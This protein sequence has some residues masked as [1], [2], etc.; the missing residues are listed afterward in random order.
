MKLPKFN[1]IPWYI[2][3]AVPV[4]AVLLIVII[5]A[6]WWSNVKTNI[7]HTHPDYIATKW[8]LSKS[9]SL[10]NIA[11][12]KVKQSE[13][14]ILQKDS[15]I[16]AYKTREAQHQVNNYEISKQLNTYRRE[17]RVCFKTNFWGKTEEVPCSE[18]FK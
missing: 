8:S 6:N 17:N 12:A 1:I 14:L 18:V 15:T 4:G 9:D 2:K 10:F 11:Q 7:T 16:T 3:L 13:L 5:I